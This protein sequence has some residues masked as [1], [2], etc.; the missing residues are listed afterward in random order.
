[1]VH[2]KTRRNLSRLCAKVYR[3][4]ENVGTIRNLKNF[5]FVYSMFRRRR[6][7]F[8]SSVCLSVRPSFVREQLFDVTRLSLHLV[9]GFQIKLVTNIRHVSAHCCKVSK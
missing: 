5:S 7:V 6:Y 4:L 3:F 1:M 2:Q 8:Q 9:D